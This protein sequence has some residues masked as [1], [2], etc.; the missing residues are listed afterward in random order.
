MITFALA[1]FGVALAAD[2][3]DS[4]AAELAKLRRSVETLS[5][6]LAAAKED[7]DHHLDAVLAERMDLDL[8]IRRE[9]LRAAV[10]RDAL[11]ERRRALADAE[12]A[13]QTALTPALLAAIERVRDPVA[14]SLPVHR[15]ERLAELDALR[16]DLLSGALRPEGGVGRLWAF[17]EDELRLTR[18]N[19]LDRQVITVDGADVLAEVGR[20]GMAAAYFRTDGGAVGFAGYGAAEGWSWRTVADRRESNAVEELIDALAHGVR[21]GTFALPNPESQP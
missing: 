19:G 5:T 14:R 18:E 1:H 16:D 12:V 21:A 10:A 9:E 13:G 3:V 8:Q 15:A 4:R 2:P 11:A 20:L 6:A 17:V 7:L